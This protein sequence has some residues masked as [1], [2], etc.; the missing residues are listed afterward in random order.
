MS[1]AKTAL[2]RL[3]DLAR[4]A[5]GG[6]LDMIYPPACLVCRRAIAEQGGLCPACWCEIAFI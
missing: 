2:R 3:S 6:V 1:A 5:G 4:R